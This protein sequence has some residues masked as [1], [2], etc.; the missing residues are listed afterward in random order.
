M[1]DTGDSVKTQPFREEHTELRWAESPA[2]P[3][4][5]A[6]E[7]LARLMENKALAASPRFREEHPELLRREPAFEIAPLK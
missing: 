5:S 3:A 2:K 4:V 6:N 1:I 7:G